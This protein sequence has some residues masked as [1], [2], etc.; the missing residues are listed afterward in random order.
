MLL[1]WKDDFDVIVSN[2]VEE[3]NIIMSEKML[4]VTEI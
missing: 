2:H 4:S 1:S 3:K